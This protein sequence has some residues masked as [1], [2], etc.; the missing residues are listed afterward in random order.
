MIKAIIFDL[1]GV[2]ADTQQHHAQI[3]SEILNR[4]GVVVSPEEIT[5]KYAGIRTEDFLKQLLAGKKVDFDIKKIMAEKWQR[6]NEICRTKLVEVPGASSL[7]KTAYNSNLKLAVASA[8]S[9]DFVRMVLKKLKIIKYFSVFVSADEVGKGKPNPDV[10]LL[11]ARKLLVS[12]QNCVVIE[13]SLNGMLAAKA[14]GMK[15]IGLT[16]NKKA[17][18]DLI[19]NSFV[20]LDINKI[21]SL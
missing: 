14:A 6:I 18:A 9:A 8:S 12:S 4:F 13:D 21:K 17:P 16:K 20:E 1:D 19:I 10:F 7:I 3:E 5:K 15:C 11:A 2:I